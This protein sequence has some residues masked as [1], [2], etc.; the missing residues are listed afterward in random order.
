MTV[1][2]FCDFRDPSSHVCKDVRHLFFA[3][4]G[5]DFRRFMRDGMTADELRGPGQH[6]DKIDALEATA[7]IREA[8]EAAHG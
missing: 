4:F 5:L 2:R 3:R 1:I 7:R 8:R 6:L